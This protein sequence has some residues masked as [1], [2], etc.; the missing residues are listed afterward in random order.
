[1]KFIKSIYKKEYLHQYLATVTAS[2]SILSVGINTAWTSPYLPQITNGSYPGISITSDE[3]SWIAIMPPLASPIGALIAAN[4]VDRIG[5]KT[6]TLLMAPVTFLMFITLA[7]AKSTLLFCIIRF[8]IG[9]L[10]SILYTALAM[11]LG[12][13]SHPS[14][15]GILTASV[16]FSSLLGSLLINLL[17]FYFSIFVSSLI[18]AAIPVIH[19]LGF[20]WMPE[21][22]YYFIRKNMDKEA[23]QSLSKLR[24]ADE[25]E[26]EFKTLSVIVN[27][28]INKKKAHF[29]DVFT[30]KSNR[31]GLF[32]FIILN[33]TRK[34]S[35]SGPFLFYTASIF[36][37]AEGSVNANVSVT[38]FLCIQIAS[39]MV[40]LNVLDFIGRRPVII[41]SSVACIITLS[42]S[43]TYFYCKDYHPAY[44]QH[45]GWVPLTVLTIYMV[46]YNLGLELTPIVY[47]SELFPTSVKAYALA[48]V[49]VISACNGV[50][51]LK[52]FQILTDNY[53]MYL[54]FWVFAMCCA[55][56][57]VLIVIY[58][59]ETKNKT[60]EEIQQDLVKRSGTR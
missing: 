6:T 44:L 32:I 27:E 15:R 25:V 36:Q 12:E 31:L 9:C 11:Y 1:M 30:V 50:I 60:L 34:F 3:G 26:K 18:C 14:I 53:G 20:M 45:F 39:A 55:V 5:R 21:S 13:I 29:W 47:A 2:F 57:L 22:P 56:G 10:A 35:G 7:F 33:S 23:K 59:P 58:V 8:V 40:S 41:V 37:T 42:V 43:G 38:I 24:A 51:T 46:F 52:I 28:E 19:F 17:G 48:L 54:P 4:L 16:A 49:D